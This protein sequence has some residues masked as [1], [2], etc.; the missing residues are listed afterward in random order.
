MEASPS[1]AVTIKD[2]AEW[3]HGEV[4][5]SQ[6]RLTD[7]VTSLMVGVLGMDPSPMYFGLKSDKAVITRG[8][9]ADIQLGALETP[10]KCLVLTGG[11]QPSSMVLA[12]AKEKSVPV[13]VAREDTA[14]ILAQLERCMGQP[15]TA[16][17]AA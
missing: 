12:R 16:S 7:S 2:I 6:E 15:N 8:D 11:I 3:I 14:T 17:P 5:N 4:L 1:G 9:R 13:I 10:I